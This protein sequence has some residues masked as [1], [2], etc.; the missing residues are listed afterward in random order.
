MRS[1]EKV[2][3]TVN[4]AVTEALIELGARQR[5]EILR[6]LQKAQKGY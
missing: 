6:L 3:K 5:K 4:D 1:V 2:G